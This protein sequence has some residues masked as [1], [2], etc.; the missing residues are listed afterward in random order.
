MYRLVIFILS[1]Y[2]LAILGGNVPDGY[3]LFS[4]STFWAL[5]AEIY[6]QE[7]LSRWI[8]HNFGQKCTRWECFVFSRY[9]LAILGENAP[10]EPKRG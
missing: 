10:A 8:S 6:C 7:I 9:I 1:R 5:W 2:I 3:L 4:G